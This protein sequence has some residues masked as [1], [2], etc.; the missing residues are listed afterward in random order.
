MAIPLRALHCVYAMAQ[1][2]VKNVEKMK[3]MNVQNNFNVKKNITGLVRPALGINELVA[4]G[5]IESC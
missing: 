4:P 2:N 5:L 3:I 1:P